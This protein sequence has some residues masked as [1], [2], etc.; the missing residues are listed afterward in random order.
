MNQF[1]P[2]KTVEKPPVENQSGLFF[3]IFVG[4]ITLGGL[5]Y[6]YPASNT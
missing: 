6:L 2:P 3:W 5:P 4:A 1:D